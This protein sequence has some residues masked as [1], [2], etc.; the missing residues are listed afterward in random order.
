MNARRLTV[1]ATL[2]LTISLILTGCGGEKPP[3]PISLPGNPIEKAA[4]QGLRASY[5]DSTMW[6]IQNTSVINV[7]AVAP[8]AIILQNHD[9]K[10]LYCV[11]VEYEARYKVAWATSKGSEWER[12]VRNV[13]VM[14]T[15]ADTYIA[16]RPMNVCST[17]CE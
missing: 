5:Q 8:T 17:F 3:A 10:E 2:F 7:T 4:I 14:K 9:P 6:Q 12:T 13:L 11:C 15:Q 16:M 1:L